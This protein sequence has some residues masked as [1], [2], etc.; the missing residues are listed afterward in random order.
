MTDQVVYVYAITRDP[1]P[2]ALGKV[3]GVDGAPV[4]TIVSDDLAAVVSSVDAEEFGEHGLRRN[5]EDIRWLEKTVRGHNRVVEA[6]AAGSAAAPMGLATV[7]YQDERVREALRERAESFRRVLDEITGRTEWGVKGYADL[8]A[9][10][11]QDTPDEAAGQSPGAAY[12]S[13]L[14]HR[15]KGRAEAEEE[16]WQLARRTHTT[17]DELAHASRLHP[18]QNREL[19]G[20]EGVMV[21]NGAY[22]VDEARNDEFASAV[23]DLGRDSGALRLELT[24]PW[25]P[26]SFA[27]F[28]EQPA[29]EQPAQE[30]R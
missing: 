25:P 29:Q 16:S 28:Q 27:T 8:D 6:V 15:R 24:G 3:D 1:A 7:Y 20:Y 10:S 14:R 9:Y 11:K 22:L 19:A 2:D 26:Y 4:R 5:L 30:D 13:R 23:E 17:L 21:L 12:L 18:A